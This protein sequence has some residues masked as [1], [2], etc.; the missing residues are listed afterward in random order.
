MSRSAVSAVFLAIAVAMTA[1]ACGSSASSSPVAG[2]AYATGTATSASPAADPLAGMSSNQIVTTALNNLKSATGVHMAGTVR[3]SGQAISLDLALV[4]SKG[5][6]GSMSL[7]GKGSLKLV[8]LD[9][10]LWMK[11]DDQFYK[12]VGASAAVPLLSGKWVKPGQNSGMSD[13]STFC[14]VSGVAGSFAKSTHK[15]LTKA[16]GPPING[17]PTVMIKDTA[18][19][20]AMYVSDVA[21]PEILR[22]AKSGSD[23]GHIDFSGYGTPVMIS[24][25]PASQTIN[26][27]QFGF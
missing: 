22:I 4:R 2:S 10:N 11:P 18:D 1:A 25:P 17:Q 26:G 8:Y 27:A 15:G 3:S 14:T 12:S 24:A 5:C 6:S 7:A 13:F 21:T 20:A 19:S 23:G 16:A 9:K